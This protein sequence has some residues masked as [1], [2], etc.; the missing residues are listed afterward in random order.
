MTLTALR[1]LSFAIVTGTVAC[2]LIL[3][4]A[5]VDPQRPPERA[6]RLAGG[7]AA[8]APAS[9]LLQRLAA[10]RDFLLAS[11]ALPSR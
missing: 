11:T 7:P 9:P 3:S 2:A 1:T 6:Q 4:T 8:A 5:R 10:A